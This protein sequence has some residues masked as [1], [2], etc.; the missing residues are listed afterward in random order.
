[1]KRVFNFIVLV[2]AL[3]IVFS[4]VSFLSNAIIGGFLGIC[5]ACGITILCLFKFAK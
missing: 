5:V 4:V 2:V 1:M 3:S